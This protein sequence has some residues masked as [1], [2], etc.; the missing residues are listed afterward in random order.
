[1]LTASPGRS[2]SRTRRRAS[3]VRLGTGE[4]Q[5]HDQHVGVVPPAA[6]RL[7]VARVGAERGAHTRDL[8]RGDRRAGARSSRT[9]RPC[10]RRRRRQARRPAVRPRPIRSS[11]PAG[12]PTTT[13]SW[14]RAS[15]SLRR[16]SVSVVRSSDPSTMRT[17]ETLR[18]EQRGPDLVE[19]LERDVHHAVRARTSRRD[20]PWRRRRR[21]ASP[22]CGRWCRRR[23]APW[24]GPGSWASLIGA[25]LH[26]P[27]LEHAQQRSSCGNSS[28]PE[29]PVDVVRE[30]RETERRARLLRVEAEAVRDHADLGARGPQPVD[31]RLEGRVERHL[32]RAAARRSASAPRQQVPLVEQ[33]DPAADRRPPRTRRRR[34][35]SRA[36]RT[37]RAGARR[38]RRC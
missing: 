6:P 1:M 3:R 8:V 2:R 29:A 9:A 16:Q 22:P 30:H 25:C 15:R 19:G 13:R 34:P 23:R 10:R 35:A 17:V 28:S 32:A 31:E 33:A 27:Q 12:G 26:V 37:P 36:G 20:G 24:H 18:P 11:S 7:A 21:R 38:R 4:P 14:P 5:A